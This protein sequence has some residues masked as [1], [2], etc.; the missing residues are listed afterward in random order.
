MIQQNHVL[1]AVNYR[2]DVKRFRHTM[3]KID[4][5]LILGRCKKIMHQ[6]IPSINTPSPWGN[7]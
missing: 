7:F 1:D 5:M 2:A 4:I 6:S 3:Q